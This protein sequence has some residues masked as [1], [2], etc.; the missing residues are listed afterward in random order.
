MSL[1]NYCANIESRIAGSERQHEIDIKQKSFAFRSGL[2][3]WGFL[4]LFISLCKIGGYT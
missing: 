2:L 3:I 4:A 1:S